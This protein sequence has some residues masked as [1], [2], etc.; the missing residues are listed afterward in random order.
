[1]SFAKKIIAS[2]M[3]I[4]FLVFLFP[5]PAGAEGV[6]SFGTVNSKGLRLRDAASTS[7]KILGRADVGDLVIVIGETITNDEGT[8][9][10]VNYSGQ[11]GFMSS[12]YVDLVTNTE[13]LEFVGVITE[14]AVNFR[15]EPNL[16]SNKLLKFS[17]NQNVTVTSIVS[18]W[19][20]VL[21]N[22]QIGYVHPDFINV[23]TREKQID[24]SI[25]GAS[26]P[27]ASPS[28]SANVVAEATTGTNLQLATEIIDYA[29]TF[30]G[31]KYQYGMSNGVKFD[32]SGFT[33]YVFKAFG[34][35]LSRTAAGQTQDG[36]KISSVSDLRK[37]D[38][39]L[40]RDT[41]INKAAASHT[42][43]Y[44]GDGLFIH[45]SSTKKE[46]TISNLITNTYYNKYFIFG[47]RVLD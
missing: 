41:K 6:D 29:K 44:I 27:S 38:L 28:A 39:V 30:L 17:K 12:Q 25:N 26:A 2:A 40:F 42:G 10:S 21:H 34:Y 4:L 9:Y 45:A 32:C 16:T 13:N 11:L 33:T 22:S 20:E 31:C 3:S 1:M 15:A 18:G 7:G 19:F 37:G 24:A 47:S 43:I 46:V 14:N 8:W 35:K 36:T 23:T 5:V